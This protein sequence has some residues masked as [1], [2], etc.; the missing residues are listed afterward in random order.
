MSKKYQKQSLIDAINSPLDSKLAGKLYNIPASTIRRHRRNPFLRNRIGRP[1]YLSSNEESYFVSMLQLL[2]E[3]G[4][5]ITSEVALR[6]AKDYFESL[7][8]SDNPGKKWLHSLVERHN[9]IRWKKES[10]LERTREEAFTEEI[11][12]GWFPLLENVM[13]KYNLLD[14]PAQIFNVDE[15]GFSD[16][17]KDSDC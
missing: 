17:T 7:N 3:I 14:K 8:L 2:P 13:I 6:L 9:E 4:F 1:S 5:Q 16:Q 10:K 11:R 12:S 15:I